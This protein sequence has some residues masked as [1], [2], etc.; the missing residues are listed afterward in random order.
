M[1]VTSILNK[2][3][4]DGSGMGSEGPPW[5]VLGLGNP[6][7]EYK[8]T[9]HNVG[10]W[11][12]DELVSRTSAELNRKRK[13]IRYAEVEIEGTAAVLAYPRT[14]MNRSGL[15][16]SYLTNRYKTPAEKILVVTDDINLKPGAVRIR[17]KG[18]P[19]GHN[20]LKSIITAL[21]TNE[22]PRVRIG[23]GNPESGAQQVEH[24]LGTFDPESREL[25]R[26]AAN[27][28]ADAVAMI[29]A[30]DIDNAMNRHNTNG[31]GS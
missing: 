2:L 10:W 25:V 20:G 26:S 11:C 7:A 5:I 3:F 13:E 27:R 6:G 17:K 16:L 8:N 23:V 14:L 28:S 21:S 15:V 29:V 22:F 12:L 30:G 9:R 1:D 4:P 19:G 18:S 31:D 24:V